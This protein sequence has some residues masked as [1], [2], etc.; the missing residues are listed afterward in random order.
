MDIIS[1]I[2]L[3]HKAIV[4]L[5]WSSSE[6]ADGLEPHDRFIQHRGQLG[7][8]GSAG[9]SGRGVPGVACWVGAWEGGIPGTSPAEHPTATNIQLFTVKRPYEPIQGPDP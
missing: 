4:P 1:V 7:H 6:L 8:G 2:N 9:C 5:I 3:G